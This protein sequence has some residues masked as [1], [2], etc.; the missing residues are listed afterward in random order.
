MRLFDPHVHMS[1]R[2]TDDYEKMLLAGIE[3]VVEPAFWLG[4]PRTCAGSFYDYFDLIIDW[5]TQRARN[6]GVDHYCTISVNPREANDRALTAEVMKN[7]PRFLAKDRVVAVGEIGFDYIT[8]AEEEAFVRQSEIAREHKLP[9]LIHTSHRNKPQGTER[10]IKLLQ[11][12]DYDREMVLIDHNTEDTIDMV[13]AAGY[14]AGHTV[15]PVTKLTPERA[16]NIIEKHGVERMMVNSSADWGLSDPLS[17]PRTVA[18]LRKRGFKEKDL[19]TLVWH[20]PM[21][22]FGQSGRLRVR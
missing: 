22:F 10:M 1:S 20:N 5:E 16:A 17:V 9:L 14:W 7:L 19:E 12:M 15:Y 8:D 21:K 4:Q 2:V 18:E 6:C 13:R 11:K 3:V